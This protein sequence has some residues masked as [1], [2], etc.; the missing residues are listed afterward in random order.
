MQ[1]VVMP[2]VRITFND[3]PLLYRL[4]GMAYGF[5]NNGEPDSGCSFTISRDT[6]ESFL[7]DHE[8]DEA[9]GN[10]SEDHDNF[11]AY[12]YKLKAEIG[13]HTFV[14]IACGHDEFIP[15]EIGS[16]P[17]KPR[18][19]EPGKPI[20]HDCGN[21]F[22][23]VPYNAVTLN[24][25]ELPQLNNEKEPYNGYWALIAPCGKAIDGEGGVRPYE[26]RTL[27]ECKT[28]AENLHARGEYS[29]CGGVFSKT[30]NTAAV[31]TVGYEPMYDKGIAE[32]GNDF[33]K[34][35][36]TH[37]Y[38]GGFAANTVEDAK[39]LIVEHGDGKGWAIYELD[40]DWDR[41]TVQAS[42]GWWRDLLNDSV[43]LRKVVDA[44]GQDIDP[45]S[46]DQNRSNSV[47]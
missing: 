19:I 14:L 27:D 18:P 4:K 30:L 42:N 32:L 21:G 39:R 43:I 38:P 3:L 2:M 7:V 36:R 8:T 12:L 47:G 9:K 25:L 6:V 45:G 11:Y 34:K 35:G 44:K 20:R 33:R 31:Y 1:Y 41:D 40:A 24:G 10:V 37:D 5:D 26:Y 17:E 46:G 22:F 23:A 15:Y 28:D 16:S 13:L 29:Y